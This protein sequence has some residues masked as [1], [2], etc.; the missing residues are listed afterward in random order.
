VAER[1][2]TGVCHHD[3]PDSCVWDVT[4]RDGQAVRLRG[5]AS[6]PFTR[7]ELCPKVNRFLDRVHHP[8]RVLHPLVRTGAKGAAAFERTTWDDALARIAARW[9]GLIDA[10]G[11]ASILPFGYAGNQ[12]ILQCRTMSER[13]FNALGTS[14]VVGGLCGNTAEAG[15]RVTQ[16]SGIGIDPEDLRHSRVILLWSTNTLVTNRHLWPI[17]DEARAAGAWVVC[18]D[19]LRTRTAAACDEH[20]QPLP[21]TDAALALGM[22]HVLLAKGLVD[23][24]YVRDHAEGYDEL[25]ERIREWPPERAAEI[26]GLATAD[27]ERLAVRYGEGE[28]SA[29][30]VLIGMEHRENGGMAYRAISC[31]P[32]LTGA[33]RHRGGG[34]VRSVDALYEELLPIDALRRPDLRP[35]P[36]RPIEMGKLGEALTE[37]PDDDAVRAL[38]VYNCN[39]AAVVPNQAKVLAGLQREDLFTVVIEQF[40]TDTARYADVVLPATTQIEHLDLMPAWGHLY[41]T[42]NQ[43]AIEPLGDALPNTEIFRRLA[44]AMDLDR[45]EL[46]TSDEDLLRELLAGATHPFMAGITYER[47]VA[48]GSIKVGR[49]V[50]WRPYATG[51]FATASGKAQL[52]APGLAD[53]GLDPLP[54]WTPARE[55]L[56]GD[57]ARRARFPLSCI[58]SKRHQR[59]LNS[60]YQKLEAHTGPEGEPRLE[61]SAV[62]AAARG[63]V[64][65]DRVRVWN[66]RGTMELAAVISDRVRPQLVSV[67]FGW[68]LEAAGG[69]SCNTLTSDVS[70]DLGGGTSFHDTLV[71]VA[72]L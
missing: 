58:T 70:T 5:Q 55:G 63:I 69:V 22:M 24:E 25:R 64:D 15:L 47:L 71:E 60:S 53:R 30:R 8:D 49:P 72:R 38:V 34:L 10:H 52:V 26:C 33:W 62:D 19:P 32:I 11:P 27:I 28:P 4:V 13:L 17:I 59:F 9:R 50:D 48:E 54:T 46:R 31:L 61:I 21:G 3:C 36:R 42:L 67:P 66:D 68:P 12:G 43:P 6:H 39:P 65:G 18:I 57:A 41:L 23:D 45:P 44:A 40:V 56:H 29:I 35:H 2:V 51:G 37:L 1:V 16:G 7:G 14:T 20:V